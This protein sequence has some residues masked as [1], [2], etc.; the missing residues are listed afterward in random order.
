MFL[1]KLLKSAFAANFLSLSYILKMSSTEKV[2]QGRMIS[3]LEDAIKIHGSGLC[4]TD[5]AD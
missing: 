5:L 1:P 4:N 3:S 2:K